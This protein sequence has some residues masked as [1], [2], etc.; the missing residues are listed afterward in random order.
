MCEP[1][2]TLTQQIYQW[3]RRHLVSTAPL[4]WNGGAYLS[5]QTQTSLSMTFHSFRL[6][7]APAILLGAANTR[8]RSLKGSVY[9]KEAVD[10][11]D[12]PARL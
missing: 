3:S 12:C 11:T 5:A 10:G 6:F 1:L 4:A 8:D 7:H 9:L 2:H